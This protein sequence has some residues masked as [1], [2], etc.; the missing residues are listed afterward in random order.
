[1]K[2]IQTIRCCDECPQL[3]KYE[4]GTLHCFDNGKKI[5]KPKEGYWIDI[6]KWC[7]LPDAVESED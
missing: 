2:L 6:P 4:D 1:M 7:P 3:D 5:K